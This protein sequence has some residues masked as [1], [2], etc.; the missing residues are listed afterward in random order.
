MIKRLA[1]TFLTGLFMPL[2]VLMLG[3]VLVAILV[4]SF[5]CGLTF[6]WAAMT[7]VLYA[8]SHDHTMLHQATVSG[9]GGSVGFGLLMVAFAAVYEMFAKLRAKLSPPVHYSLEFSNS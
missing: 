7:L 2:G 4:A 6:L 9:I 8:L 1:L 5:A 3:I